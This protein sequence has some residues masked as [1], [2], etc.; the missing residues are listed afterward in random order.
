MTSEDQPILATAYDLLEAANSSLPENRHTSPNA[1]REVVRRE[2]P[3]VP[4]AHRA[5][6]NFLTTIENPAT[7]TPTIHTDLL[8]V[9]HPLST[10]PASGK[11]LRRE[12]A[13]YFSADPALSDDLA[14]IIASAI[15]CEPNTPTRA[16]Y[17]ELLYARNTP[18]SIFATIEQADLSIAKKAQAS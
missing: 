8:P 17:E 11:D 12:T 10:T 9:G 14:P 5:V 18:V 2:L 1:V 4:K 16:F 6:I 3:S 15:E 13:R 7:N